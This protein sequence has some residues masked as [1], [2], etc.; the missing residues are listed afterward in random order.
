MLSSREEEHPAT[1]AGASL[2]TRECFLTPL[3]LPGCAIPSKL[4][5]PL[6]KE[7]VYADLLL[8]EKFAKGFNAHDEQAAPK[9][10]IMPASCSPR[11]QTTAEPKQEHHGSG[12]SKRESCYGREVMISSLATC[13]YFWAVHVLT[14]HVEGWLSL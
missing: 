12:A 5:N 3:P 10:L 9:A 7:R 11:T 2:G 14:S 4:I 1:R 8:T 13:L 6:S